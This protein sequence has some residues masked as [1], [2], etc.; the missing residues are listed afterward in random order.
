MAFG[1]DPDNSL[2][3]AKKDCIDAM[4]AIPSGIGPVTCNGYGGEIT[5]KVKSGA[6]QIE[7]QS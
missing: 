2:R 4:R 3:S 1:K 7:E 6:K 5:N